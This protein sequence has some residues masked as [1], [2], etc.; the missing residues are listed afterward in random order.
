M[1]NSRLVKISKY[2]SRHLR[3][4]PERIGLELQPGGWIFIEELLEASKK[5][6]FQIFPNELKV[7][8]EQNN[9]KRFSFDETG[10]RIRANQGH[11]VDVDLQLKP[12]V[13]P[14]T[15]YHGTNHHAVESI[16][17]MGLCK[18]S[19]HHVHLSTDMNTA[20]SVGKRR[21]QP[22]IFAVDAVKMDKVG[23]NFY[24]TENGVWLVDRVPPEYLQQL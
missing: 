20:R 21:G 9:K 11:T 24:C 4:C 2:L 14:D 16:R 22:I 3:H 15:L 5:N 19:R 7:V 1:K 23:Y 18:M 8:V 13:P 10:T 17:Q 12:T 6:K